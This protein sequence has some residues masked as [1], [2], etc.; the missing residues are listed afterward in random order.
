MPLDQLTLRL[1][2]EIHDRSDLPMSSWAIW[3]ETSPE[4]LNSQGEAILQCLRIMVDEQLIEVHEGSRILS[5][6]CADEPR[7]YIVEGLTDHGRTL[8]ENSS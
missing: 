4:T 8:L 7:E 1:L 2:R 3:P 5:I 6:G